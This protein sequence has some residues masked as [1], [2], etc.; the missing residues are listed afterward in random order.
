MSF[1]SAKPLTPVSPPATASGY[2]AASVPLNT[3]GAYGTS[4]TA[5]YG[6]SPTRA[7]GSAGYPTGVVRS[8]AGIGF[9]NNMLGAAVGVG[10]AAYAAGATGV[11][12]GMVAGGRAAG[13]AIPGQLQPPG[14]KLE[15]FS[16]SAGQWL[17]ATVISHRADGLYHL[18]IKNGAEPSSVRLAAN[19][20]PMTTST[21]VS[22]T[23]AMATN[24]GAASVLGGAVAIHSGTA[25]ASAVY[26]PGVIAVSSNVNPASLEATTPRA[27]SVIGARTVDFALPSAVEYI[28]P[29]STRSEKENGVE[30]ASVQIAGQSK[31]QDVFGGDQQ[32]RPSAPALLL[33]DSLSEPKR[34]SIT[35]PLSARPSISLP[36]ESVTEPHTP[37]PL[38]PE[39]AIPAR[40][41]ARRAFLSEGQMKVSFA[42]AE[43]QRERRPS[44]ASDAGL[45]KQRSRTTGASVSFRPSLTEYHEFQRKSV[46]RTHL[47]TEDWWAKIGSARSSVTSVCSDLSELGIGQPVHLAACT[48]RA[49]QGSFA[50]SLPTGLEDTEPLTPMIP[51][52]QPRQPLTPVARS[53]GAPILLPIKARAQTS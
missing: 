26:G 32:R 34:P 28:A 16:Q 25:P 30:L 23:S 44:N 7:M 43:D 2:A 21:I 52:L 51:Q 46:E 37:K 38:L 27:P 36:I 13:Y 33:G 47:F 41:L 14:T 39:A 40:S 20:G 49:R 18:D 19:T 10:P 45:A 15:Y 3:G 35:L 50:F 5:A 53:P 17:P 1:P 29:V 8:T 12:A 42:E 11:A 9:A 24:T 4:P 48:P 6:N 22:N 31:Q